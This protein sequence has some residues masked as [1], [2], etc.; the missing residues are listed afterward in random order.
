MKT[1]A[2]SLLALPLSAMAASASAAPV[3][4]GGRLELMVD[5]AL[6]ESLSG[7]ARLALHRPVP[8]EVVFTTD[9]PW[10]GNASAYQSVFRD[11]DGYRMVYRGGHYRHGGAPAETRE[12][13]PWV[14]C[15]AESADGITWRRPEVGRREWNGSRANNI[16]V[17]TAM[18]AAFGGCPAHTAAFIDANPACPPDQRYKIIAYGT[19]PK[20]LYV[21]GSPDG[22]D[23][24]VLSERPI[25]TVGAFDSQNLVFWDSER[26]EYR[27]YHRGFNG[28]VR[29]IL[30][31]VSP[32]ILSFPEPQ[33][34]DYGDS[35]TMALY[36]NQIQP[37]SRAPHLFMGFPMRYCDRGW[38]EPM[39]DLPGAEVRAAR[40]RHHPRYGTTITDAV[41]MTSRDGLHFRRWSEAFLR[42]GPRQSGSWVYGDNFLF[43]GM[44]ETP[45]VFGDA[46]PELSLYGTENYWEGDAT[47]IRRYSLRVDGF[48]S[49]GAP[50][51]GGE[52]LT[53]PL[54]FTGGNLALNLETSAYG[55]IQVEIQDAGGNPLPGYALDDCPPIFGDRLRHIVRWRDRGGDLRGL[56][57]TPVRLRLRLRDA[58][59]YAFQ[60]VPY[61]PEPPR[62]DL[63][64]TGYVPAKESEPRGGGAARL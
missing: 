23:F 51:E 59:L 8:R 61:A 36:T 41:F 38:S 34:L 35:P 12:A 2:T 55:S 7:A 16:I 6:I 56:E 58:D 13:H 42:P 9:A 54:R 43:W 19:R 24:R 11:G 46:P 63:S 44:V 45:S 20:G 15:V 53:R 33:W 62:P 64:G 40:A 48:V 37:Y 32:D 49:A 18:M 25:Q 3:S 14:L 10:E 50:Y 27:M 5:D 39:L 21:L 57:G 1:I 26:R 4:I 31:A 30:T 28:E 22:F 52:V 29:D 17:D 60:F 47:S